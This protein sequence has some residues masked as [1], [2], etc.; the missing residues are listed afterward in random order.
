MV[1]SSSPSRTPLFGHPPD[2][3]G[4]SPLL[5]CIPSSLTLHYPYSNH[6][7]VRPVPHSHPVYPDTNQ[8]I[9]LSPVQPS[10]STQLQLS[11]P[12]VLLPLMHMYY[13][14]PSLRTVLP[15]TQLVVFLY[16]LWR[17]F[18]IFFPVPRLPHV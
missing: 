12:A 3:H 9:R 11:I 1:H 4:R 17:I 7:T 14:L 15:S 5:H 6:W 10:S 13:I 2:N 18:H 8:A 16:F